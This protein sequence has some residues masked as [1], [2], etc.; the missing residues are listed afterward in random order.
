MRVDRVLRE[1]RGESVPI[2]HMLLASTSLQWVSIFLGSIL[3]YGINTPLVTNWLLS[4]FQQHYRQLLERENHQYASM[5]SSEF[6]SKMLLWLR[7][8]RLGIR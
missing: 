4:E 2:E 5:A 7:D 6:A 1:Q 3:W 8:Y